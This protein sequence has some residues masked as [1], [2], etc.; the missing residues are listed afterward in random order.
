MLT[1]DEEIA[2]ALVVGII[3]T[4]FLKLLLTVPINF[5]NQFDLGLELADF[6]NLFAP[7]IGMHLEH[8]RGRKVTKCLRKNF[9]EEKHGHIAAKSVAIHAG[10]LSN[11]AHGHVGF[12]NAVV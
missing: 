2:D 8:G 1:S 6:L 7:K 9:R 4:Q 10:G 5:S 11:G 12:Q 3:E